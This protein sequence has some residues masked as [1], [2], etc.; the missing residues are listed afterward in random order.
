MGDDHCHCRNSLL[1][2][3]F[4]HQNAVGV[5]LSTFMGPQL[6]LRT[7]RNTQWGGKV[8]QLE[9]TEAIQYME[10]LDMASIQYAVHMPLHTQFLDMASI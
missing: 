1:W 7:H 9:E 10:F 6:L 5:T 2:C 8:K 3:S 4:I